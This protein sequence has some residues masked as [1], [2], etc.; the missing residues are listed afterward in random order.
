MTDSDVIRDGRI[1]GDDHLPSP[2]VGRNSH[3][4]EVTN[5][6]API[7]DGLRAE[8]CFL[9]GPSGVGKTTVAR[10]AVRELRQEV[11]EVPHAYVNCWR[12]YT[13]N[14]V[15][16]QLARDLVGAALPRSS[17][18]SRLIDLITNNLRG[19]GVVILD[20]V[21]QL[22]G[23]EVLYDL[24]DIHG[25]SWIGIA[26]REV[27]L[28]ADLDDRITSRISVAYRV[29]FDTYG[30]DTITKILTRRARGGLNPGA[31][32]EDILRRI[33]RLSEGDARQAITALRVGAQ[34]ASR[35]GLSTIPARLVD[36]AVADA[37]Q[38]VRQ[39]TISKLNTHQRALYEVL[40]EEDGLIQ[41]ELYARYQETHDDPV[42]LR[43][44]RENHLPK[45]DH[46]N[47]VDVEQRGGTK[48]YSLV[49]VD[50]QDDTLSKS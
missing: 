22:R 32:N 3:M 40:A 11:L 28:L 44:L 33:A 37:E 19:P 50:S 47:L 7:E 14:A 16:E 27:D 8:N 25:L 24:H 30:E 34:M 31:V 1:F 18:T 29:R 39:K 46:Y 36:D 48:R 20:E 23:T 41:K 45:L 42:T 5:A 15:L 9:F 12:D 10:A 43:Y 4:N 13:R 35:E 17:S 38:E 2:I 26:N 6:L 21:D 49:G